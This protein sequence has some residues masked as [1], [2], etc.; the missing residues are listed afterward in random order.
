MSFSGVYFGLLLI[1][2]WVIN[3]TINKTLSQYVG[4]FHQPLNTAN[5]VPASSSTASNALS[6][7]NSASSLLGGTGAKNLIGAGTNAA[8]LANSDQDFSGGDAASLQDEAGSLAM[9][10]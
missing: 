9:D 6:A 10:Q 7:L 1:A 4:L 2:V 3:A 5:P 8:S